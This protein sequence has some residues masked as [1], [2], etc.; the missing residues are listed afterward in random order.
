M[1]Y[2]IFTKFVYGFRFVIFGRFRFS[3][4][5]KSDST[6]RGGA[7]Y[8]LRKSICCSERAAREPDSSFVFS[9]IYGYP[10]WSPSALIR[11]RTGDGNGN[12]WQRV[13]GSAP[14]GRFHKTAGNAANTHNRRNVIAHRTTYRQHLL[15]LH[16][17]DRLQKLGVGQL[18]AIDWRWRASGGPWCVFSAY[19]VVLPWGQANPLPWLPYSVATST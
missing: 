16:D 14:V 3:T 10:P 17:A 8:D 13:I 12:D 4:F 5:M 2:G 9:N 18:A 7:A 15:R 19:G 6:I 1:A 11:P